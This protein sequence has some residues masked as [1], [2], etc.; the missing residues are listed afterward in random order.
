MVNGEVIKFKYSKVVAN[1]YKYE[2]SVDNHN[3]LMHE[4]G[5]K[6]QHILESAW[7]TT[8]WPIQVLFFIS[9]Y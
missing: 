5:T 2:G 7:E 8:W 9:V 3:A 6:S 4:S 1:H